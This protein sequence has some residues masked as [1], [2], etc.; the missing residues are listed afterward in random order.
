LLHFLFDPDGGTGNELVRLLV[1]EQNGAGVSGEGIARAR[2]QRAQEGVE[3]EVGER[4]VR[5]PLKPVEA[6]GVLDGVAHRP[7]VPGS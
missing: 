5:Q 3:L 4:G 7:I 1:E 6:V 2:Q